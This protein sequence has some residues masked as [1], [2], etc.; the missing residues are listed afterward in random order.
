MNHNRADWAKSR[1]ITA[2][3]LIVAAAAGAI[4]GSWRITAQLD[5]SVSNIETAPYAETRLQPPG[6]R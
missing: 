5:R 1:I 2:T 3:V 4:Y 6:G